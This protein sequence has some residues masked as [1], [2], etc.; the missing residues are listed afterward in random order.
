MEI[1]RF[2]K[3][4]IGNKTNV[5]LIFTN[6]FDIPLTDGQSFSK[7]KVRLSNNWI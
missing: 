7:D 3:E 5:S 2:T 6:K 4:N 1:L